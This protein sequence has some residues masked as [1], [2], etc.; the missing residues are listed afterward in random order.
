MEEKLVWDWDLMEN[1]IEEEA[2]LDGDGNYTLRTEQVD[3]PDFPAHF[4]SENPCTK[5][6]NDSRVYVLGHGN[7]KS[8]KIAGRKVDDLAGIILSLIPLGVKVARLS[9]LCCWSGGNPH[10]D[11]AEKA[12]PAVSSFAWFL[13]ARVQ[14]R[15][16]S[17]SARTMLVAHGPTDHLAFTGHRATTRRDEN[18]HHMAKRENSKIIILTEMRENGCCEVRHYYAY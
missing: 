10:G 7:P 11:Y 3:V 18:D 1:V 12:C 16:A 9:L 17:V 14:D 2:V 4:R 8:T 13:Y 6:T 15:V 5:L